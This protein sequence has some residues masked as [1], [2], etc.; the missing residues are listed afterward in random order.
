MDAQY[1]Q[2]NVNEALIEALASMAI[3]MPE[4]GV[5]FIGKYLLQYV[6]RKQNRSM[7]NQ[8]FCSTKINSLSRL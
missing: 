5:E 1:L 6:S 4:D 2:Q 3:T 8:F 7:V